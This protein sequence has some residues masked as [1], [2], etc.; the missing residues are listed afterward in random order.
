[1]I[2]QLRN[3]TRLR[4][5][6]VRPLIM[7][8]VG[9]A[10]VALPGSAHAQAPMRGFGGGSNRASTAPY[11]QRLSPYLDLLRSDNS[12]L[13]PY[14]SFVQP[15]QQ[16]RQSQNRQAEQLRR[17]ERTIQRSAAPTAQSERMQTGRGGT[18]NNF[19]HYYQFNSAHQ[20]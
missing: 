11:Q 8:P 15:R 19:L 4:D 18:F 3:S 9:L 20:R 6:I 1:M 12:V 7:V 2:K 17:L 14:H 10:L 16:M 5:R 13:S